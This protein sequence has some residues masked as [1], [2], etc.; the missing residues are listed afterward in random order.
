MFIQNDGR[1]Y[2]FYDRKC[3]KNMRKLSRKPREVGWTE[4]FHKV[5]AVQHKK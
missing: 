4:E 3:E 1:V 2:Y 5:K